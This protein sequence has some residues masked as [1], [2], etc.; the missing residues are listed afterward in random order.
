MYSRWE[1]YGLVESEDGHE[2]TWQ[3]EWAGQSF[4]EM[5]RAVWEAKRTGLAVRVEWR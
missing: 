1:V 4:I 5:V 3:L 2:L